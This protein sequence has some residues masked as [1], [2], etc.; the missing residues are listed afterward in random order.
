M[1]KEQDI[2]NALQLYNEFSGEQLDDTEYE[3]DFPEELVVFP[4]GRLDG[5]MYS[6]VRD[7]IKQKYFHEFK[8]KSAP[9]LVSTSDGEQLFIVGGNYIFTETGINDI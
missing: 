4:I 9:L 2:K 7:G 8:A 1:N 5:V 6:T 3:L